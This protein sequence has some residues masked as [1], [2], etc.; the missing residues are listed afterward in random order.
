M[1]WLTAAGV[2]MMLLMCDHFSQ[3]T[4]HQMCRGGVGPKSKLMDFSHLL[5][6]GKNPLLVMMLFFYLH[7]S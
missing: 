7:L 6:Y 1:L 3:D 2:L 5:K 4:E